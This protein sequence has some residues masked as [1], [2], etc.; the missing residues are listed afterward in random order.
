M[1]RYVI[2]VSGYLVLRAVNH[3]MD[4]QYQKCTYGNGVSYFSMNGT[5]HTDVSTDSTVT[6]KIFENDGLPNF[7]RYGA[8]LTACRSSA[9]T[10]NLVPLPGF[11]IRKSIQHFVD[12]FSGQLSNQLVVR[13]KP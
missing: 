2:L 9:T 11:N 3:N 10:I 4:V 6:T 7:L 12:A 13:Q 1:Q 5:W 8:P